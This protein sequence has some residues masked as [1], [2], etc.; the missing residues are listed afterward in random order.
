[1]GATEVAAEAGH[2]TEEDAILA[3]GLDHTLALAIHARKTETCTV[4]HTPAVLCHPEDVTWEIETTRAHPDV[5]ESLACP[6]PPQ[7]SKS[8]TSSQSMDQ[9][10]ESSSSSMPRY[11][12]THTVILESTICFAIMIFEGYVS[13]A[14]TNSYIIFPS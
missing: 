8:T 9:W 6:S 7:S 14:S 1:M 10:S 12:T 5:W 3:A 4:V 11:K 2:L 13:S